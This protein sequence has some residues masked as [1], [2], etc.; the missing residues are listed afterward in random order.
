MDYSLRN[1]TVEDFRHWPSHPSPQ[2]WK[3]AYGEYWFDHDDI[4]EINEKE[5][6]SRYQYD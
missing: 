6:D 1:N 2:E 3:E 4:T 5:I